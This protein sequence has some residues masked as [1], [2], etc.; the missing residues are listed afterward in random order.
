MLQFQ[1]PSHLLSWLQCIYN[2]PPPPLLQITSSLFGTYMN[3][4]PKRRFVCWVGQPYKVIHPKFDSH[5]NYTRVE[6]SGTKT[7]NACCTCPRAGH[8]MLYILVNSGVL[9]CDYFSFSFEWCLFCIINCC[10]HVDGRGLPP[11]KKEDRFQFVLLH[12][13]LTSGWGR[14]TSWP[15]TCNCNWVHGNFCCCFYRSIRA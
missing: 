14:A 10:W 15:V 6:W 9:I 3:Q 5:G 7:I 12:R 13:V 11:T 2:P 1:Y 4:E 8:G